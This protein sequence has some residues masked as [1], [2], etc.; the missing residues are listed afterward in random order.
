MGPRQ[1][2]RHIKPGRRKISSQSRWI[3]INDYEKLPLIENFQG[4][5]Q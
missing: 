1:K 2:L 3:F 5:N 4:E